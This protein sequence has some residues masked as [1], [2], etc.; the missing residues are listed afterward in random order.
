LSGST[1]S[2]KKIGWVRLLFPYLRKHR[3]NLF[4]ALGA[5]VVGSA[6]QATAP[7]IER[8]IVD[9]VILHRRAPLLPW[10]AV[11]VL[12]GVIAF[13]AAYFRRYRG[14]RVALDVQ[15]DLRNAMFDKL[16]SLD[17]ASHDRMP[18]GQLVSRANS[19]ATL[20]QGLLSYFPN[21]TSNLLLLVSSLVI[22]LVLSPLLAVVSLVVA[23]SL[24][25]IAYRMRSQIF[26]ATWDG[27]QREGD[28]AQIVDE[29]VNGVRIVKAYGQEQRELYRLVDAAKRLY[30]SH[31]RVV[32]LQARYQPVLQSLPTM[33]Q[34]AVLALGGWMVLHHELTL[35][36]F[37]AFST[38]LTQLMSPARTLA[39]ILTVAQ[40]ARAGVERIFDLINTTPEIQDLPGAQPLP[41]IKGEVS[42]EHV[43]F[44][45]EPDE[46]VLRD[47]D[48]HISPGETVALVGTSGSG[49][50]TVTNLLPRFYEVWDGAIRIDGHDVRDVTLSSLRSQI[51]FAFEESFLFSASVSDNI[52]YGRPQATDEQIEAAAKA[53]QA[54]DFIRELPNGYDT[55]VGERG[56]SLS[57]GQRQRVALAR[58][59]VADPK[60]LVLDD[61]TS[62]VDSKVEH[63]I[64][65][66]LREIMRGRT[67]LLVA[68]RRSTLHLADRIF[69]VE[70][71]AILDQGTHEELMQ[72]CQPYRLLLSGPGDDEAAAQA[73]VLTPVSLA[74]TTRVG[75]S[76]TAVS[77]LSD[78]PV[79]R[80]RVPATGLGP[81][82]G[83]G[84]GGWRSALAPT[85]EL[86]AK[87]A[88]LHPIRDIAKVDVGV[89]ARHDPSFSLWRF[90]QRFRAAL[91]L[92]L[93]LVVLD[94]L[95]GLAGPYLI[96]Q[97]I[98]VGVLKGS[99]VAL[100]VASGIFL[101]I[102]L[103]DLLDS[104][105][106]TFVTGKT[107]ERLMLALRI[108]IW[109]H[110]QRLS[111]DYYEREMA[112]R[113]M[114]RMTTD[115]DSFES[116]LEDGLIS[117]AVSICTF[118]GVGFALCLL[119]WKLAAGT[120][121]VIIPLAIATLIFRRKSAVIYDR[122][123]E[124]IAIVMAD[125]QE[126]L[127][128]VRESQAFV[129]EEL[130]QTEFHRL[131]RRYLE[132]R[133]AA[134]RLVATYF[135]FVQFLSD[136]ADA[137]VL[138]IGAYLIYAGQLTAGALIAFLLYLDMFFSPIQQLSQ[139]F[140]AWQQA[141]ASMRRVSELMALDTL[142][143]A[144]AQ[145]TPAGRLTGQ[146]ELR[147]IRF[148]YPT[149][150]APT[151]PGATRQPPKSALN[152][153][154][155][156][157]PPGQTVAIVG[158]TGAG[159]STLAKLLCRFYDPTSGR[160]LVDGHDLR[161]LDLTSYRRQLG[162]VPQDPFL[163]A[164]TVRD[165]IAYGRPEASDAE[166][167]AAA[168]AVG[169]DQVV[170]HLAG[171]YQ[172][173]L[174]ERGRSLSTGQRQLL[175]L[176]RAELVDPPILLLDEATSNLDLA[177]EARVSAAMSRL[178]RGRTTVL[179]AHRLQTARA[180]DR[181]VVMADGLLVEDGSHE[182]LLE[183][184]GQYASMW[185]AFAL[186]DRRTGT[187]A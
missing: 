96:A 30:G 25:V 41:P 76:S 126:N 90:L 149:M 16:Q 103:A 14:G 58:A 83:R 65:L 173:V 81:G 176:A 97:G 4:L 34:V 33:G 154:D 158:Q 18:T 179:I 78:S 133:V 94:A 55:M 44:G 185:E 11:L 122:A 36:T 184:D 63:E 121:T 136:A 72:R 91:G 164:G 138:G 66:G 130:S 92:G 107:A 132:A 42:F 171:G 93:L 155:L 40:Q 38:Y 111:M 151:R 145:P 160:V 85:P 95:A 178:A 24:L 119:N 86:L 100:F 183:R 26:P 2:G 89:E 147:A 117:A 56:L 27:Q 77:H 70:D 19:D 172:Y 175:A 98:D 82:L 48:L 80:G 114:T 181:I 153:V 46:P 142:T 120:L 159:K 123:R 57:G 180:A 21:V 45:Y 124:L 102:T 128:G 64:H 105:G 108:K 148:T 162:Y 50:S 13:G 139:V 5:A 186:E 134:Q 59:L 67:T 87:V 167:E 116:L 62:A 49:K 129:H 75:A 61:G 163:F 177:T 7:L 137:V 47:F 12:I 118:A 99:Y 144:P 31:M 113:I 39:G 101:F 1:G 125:F 131:G 79:P 22:M 152:G 112:G 51:G 32:R 146:I 23:P 8:Q 68:H 106:E 168:A 109:A 71:G 104:V 127:S 174:P 37:L 3:K 43:N 29:D 143:P 35:G 9:N 187:F 140:D 60:I 28:V 115:V 166:V 74:P 17:F 15:Y 10:L 73:P 170:A 157:I 135:P 20:V 150:A 141:R 165:N 6:A 182:Q 69:V 54:H 156:V 88:A 53:A 110:L 169:A 84:G 52:R 161:S